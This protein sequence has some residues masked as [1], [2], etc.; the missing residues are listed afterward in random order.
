M[1]EGQMGWLWKEAGLICSR[2]ICTC[3]LTQT[4]TPTS[5][6]DTYSLNVLSQLVCVSQILTLCRLELLCH[7]PPL[8]CCLLHSL[9]DSSMSERSGLC[10]CFSIAMIYLQTFC[11]VLL[12]FLE[13]KVITVLCILPQPCG[14]LCDPSSTLVQL[15]E[16]DLQSKV[17]WCWWVGPTPGLCWLQPSVRLMFTERTFTNR[18]SGFP[19]DFIIYRRDGPAPIIYNSGIIRM[20]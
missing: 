14:L 10:C 18:Q 15:S 16:P 3:M 17:L 20:N 2:C 19:T 4:P 12:K 1:T 11:Q 13:S 6:S 7:L 5:G 8:L 9:S